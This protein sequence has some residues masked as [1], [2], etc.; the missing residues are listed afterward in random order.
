MSN[1]HTNTTAGESTD[2]SVVPPTTESSGTTQFLSD[3]LVSKAM[4]VDV[5]TLRSDLY[6]SSEDTFDQDIKKFLAKPVI[7]RSGSLTNTNTVSSFSDISCPGDIILGN[8]VWQQ[9]LNGF[10]GMRA[11]MVFKIVINASRFQMGRYMLAFIHTGG[12]PISD[13]NTALHISYHKNTL[14]ARTQLYRVEFDV[15]CDTTAELRVPYVSSL[16][17]TQLTNVGLFGDIGALH[18]SPYVALTEVSGATSCGYT[19]YAHLEDVELIGAANP[20]MGISDIEGDKTPISTIA[21]SASAFLDK[22]AKIPSLTSIARPASWVTG[23]IGNSAKSIGWSKPTMQK[24]TSRVVR[25]VAPGFCNADTLDAS[26]KQSLFHTNEVSMLPGFSGT[27][28]DELNITYLATKF[29][30][31]SLFSMS[32]SQVSGTQLYAQAVSPYAGVSQRT[33]TGGIIVYDYTPLQ[34]TAS[35][36]KMWRG[37]IRYKLKFVRTEFHSGRIAVC[38]FPNETLGNT[39]TVFSY[40]NSHYVQRHIIDIR[41]HNEITFVVPYIAATPYKQVVSGGASSATGTFAIYVVDSL[42]APSTVPSTIQII[43][44]IAGGEDIEFA[45]PSNFTIAPVYNVTP[46]MGDMECSYGEHMVGNSEIHMSTVV[47]SEACIGERIVSLRSMLKSYTNMSFNTTPTTGSF[48]NILPFA[49]PVCYNSLTNFFPST[50]ADLYT[51]LSAIFL[52]SRGSVRFKVFPYIYQA[53]RPAVAYNVYNTD[54]APS[55]TDFAKISTT[56]GAGTLTYLTDRLSTAQTYH[57]TPTNLIQEFEIPQ[58]HALHS[59]VNH[60]HIVNTN[61]AYSFSP[62]LTSKNTLTITDGT[63]NFPATAYFAR[64]AGDDANFGRFISIGPMYTGIIRGV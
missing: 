41:E 34:L 38:F 9:K 20:Q 17:Y 39:S 52:F 33:V 44:E 61:I 62:N 50:T 47:N 55:V 22:V 51:T 36:F 43:V 26:K 30:H 1:L 64:A 60:V 12:L 15:S 11:T 8:P 32:T 40:A 31:D 6:S 53:L 24:E 16:N 19:L 37:S 2:L 29:A 63:S 49:T 21:L 59:R 56:N 46:Q 10:L 54:S 14:E 7:L 28:V 48:M 25:D 4:P 45:I 27:D 58:Y 23:F 57:N 35:M 18:L 5:V 13:A 3:A 42:V